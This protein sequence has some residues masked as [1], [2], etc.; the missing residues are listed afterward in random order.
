MFRTP[1]RGPEAGCTLASP[2]SPR[3]SAPPGSAGRHAG[4]SQC[5]YAPRLPPA[6]P[7]RPHHSASCMSQPCV[8]QQRSAAHVSIRLDRRERCLSF[9]T[10][11]LGF[12]PE[13]SPHGGLCGQRQTVELS[14][15]AHVV[16]TA[17]KHPADRGGASVRSPVL[18]GC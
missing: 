14:R 7:S 9:R 13:L 2:S 5:L 10:G 4:P 15:D 1:T 3:S 11:D 12:K 8:L 17:T 16:A 6:G 18:P